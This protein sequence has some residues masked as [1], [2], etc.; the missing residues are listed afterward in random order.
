MNQSS[1]LNNQPL[2]RP[3][4]QQELI[5]EVKKEIK[6]IL[7]YSL[8]RKILTKFGTVPR[9]KITMLNHFWNIDTRIDSKTPETLSID[10]PVI[11]FYQQEDVDKKLLIVG[12]NGAGKTSTLLELARDLVYLAEQDSSQ[13]FP[14][15]FHLSS[16]KENHQPLHKWIISELHSKYGIQYSFAEDLIKNHLI[17]PMLDGLE[18]MELE[19]QALCAKEIN[20]MLEGEQCPPGL[21]VCSRQEKFPFPDGRLKLNGTLY[22]QSL[23]N[24]QIENY[25]AAVG[26]SELWQS[27]ETNP[28]LLELAR[29]P[30]F[31]NVMVL[32]SARFPLNKY[33]KLSSKTDLTQMLLRD[34]T[35]VMLSPVSRSNDSNKALHWLTKI[36]CHLTK[37]SK[38]EFLIENLQPSFLDRNTQKNNL[39]LLNILIFAILSLTIGGIS[40]IFTFYVLSFSGWFTFS[41]WSIPKMSFSILQLAFFLVG[42]PF[43]IF[44]EGVTTNKHKKDIVPVSSKLILPIIYNVLVLALFSFH[45]KFPNILLQEEFLFFG[46]N[47][48]STNWFF[49]LIL[50][51][52]IFI[53]LYVGLYIIAFISLWLTKLLDLPIGSK[54][55]GWLAKVVMFMF[56][57]TKIASQGPPAF[58][59]PCAGR[60][61]NGV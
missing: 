19:Y 29:K 23:T 12:A 35:T 61:T 30:F 22:I 18:E 52:G 4:N 1:N 46:T 37:E 6:N 20:Q 40:W 24:N 16:W 27:I 50:A 43:L 34:Y 3:K 9:Q 56:P 60:G 28:N 58:A 47:L 7:K 26:H 17:I 11:S 5:K 31:L 2:T 45:F 44:V 8:H 59:R 55:S 38:Q 21:V 41:I 49:S 53:L 15:I 10:A 33:Q 57:Y 54:E 14:V 36:A 51:I 48:E 13:P 39:L 25:L 42:V 32:V